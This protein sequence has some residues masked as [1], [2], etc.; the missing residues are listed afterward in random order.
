MSKQTCT[1]LTHSVSGPSPAGG[2]SC[3]HD[4]LPG[5]CII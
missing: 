3:F 4:W 2:K 5:Y 1:C